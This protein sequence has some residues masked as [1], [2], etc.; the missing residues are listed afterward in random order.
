MQAIPYVQPGMTVG[1][2]TGSTVYWFILELAGRVKQGLDIRC[3]PTSQETNVLAAQSGLTMM[4][5][6]EVPKIDVTIDGSD[7]LY[8]QLCL[9]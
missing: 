7:E 9:I 1:I 3:I 8:P 5:L 4:G 2:G 6:N